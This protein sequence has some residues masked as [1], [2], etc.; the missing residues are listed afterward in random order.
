MNMTNNRAFK[1]GILASGRGTNLQAII[2]NI[3]R[4]DLAAEVALVVSDKKDA[5]ALQRGRG[6]GIKS[7]FLDPKSYPD[8]NGYE[9]ALIDALEKE[10]VELVCLAGFMRILGK[11]FIEAFRG[12]ILN[13]HPSLL[14][15]FPGL[16]AQKKAL[17]HGVKYAGCTVHFVDETVDGGP[18]V[19][20]AAVPVYDSDDVETLSRRILEREHVI[21]SRVIQWVLENRLVLAGRK[22]T[23]ENKP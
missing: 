10:S 21:Y 2:D 1:L 19:S 11:V 22:V 3:E 14:P 13:I 12:G 4:G 15:A 17:E 16:D 18:I 23:L 9:R 7:L 5:L 6:Y 20:Q 8:Q